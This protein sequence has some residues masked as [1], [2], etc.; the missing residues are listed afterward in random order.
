MIFG[1]GLIALGV[2]AFTQGQEMARFIRDNEVAIMGT[3][4]SRDTLRAAL[5]PSPAI[6]IALGA[7]Q[8]L[9]GIGVM[10]H[11][12][13]GR[14]LGFLLA[15]F[16]LIVAVFA[17]SIAYALSGGFT[18]AVIVALVL[19]VGYVLIILALLLGGSHFRR[20]APGR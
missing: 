6:L 3:Q 10:A 8:L 18:P 5:S 1:I 13:W 7:I 9:S 17:F 4:I 12:S 20:R 16:S 15:L 14:W 2:F 19:L 11:K